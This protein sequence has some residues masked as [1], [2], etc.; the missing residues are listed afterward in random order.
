M[1]PRLKNLLAEF[2]E[3]TTPVTRNRSHSNVKPNGREKGCFQQRKIILASTCFPKGTLCDNRCLQTLSTV[4]NGWAE[5]C[6]TFFLENSFFKIL[7]LQRPSKGVPKSDKGKQNCHDFLALSIIIGG[8]IW[9]VLG[10]VSQLMLWFVLIFKV[11]NGLRTL[12][13]D[14]LNSPLDFNLSHFEVYFV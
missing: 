9:I 4:K 2:T 11:Y 3:N 13:Y 10:I 8:R 6:P 12:L 1:N 7:I 14:G 5:M